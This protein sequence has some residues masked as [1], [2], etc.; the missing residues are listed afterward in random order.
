MPESTLQSGMGT[1]FIQL[2]PGSK[3]EFLGKHMV[4]EFSQGKGSKTLQW[5]KDP[6]GPDK[7]LV[8]GSYRDAPEPVKFSIE[9]LMALT[10]DYLE[11]IDGKFTLF[12]NYQTQ[13]RVDQFHVW[14]RCEILV[15]SDVANETR[16]GVAA[17]APDQRADVLYTVE[18]EAD[19]KIV[20][21]PIAIDRQ[22]TTEVQKAN[23]V[24]FLDKNRGYAVHNAVALGTANVQYTLDGGANWAAM[25]ADPFAADLHIMAVTAFY[26]GR[27]TIR[28]LVVRGTLAG[29]PLAV[30]YTDDN[31]ATWTVKTV[32]SVAAQAAQG[33][34]ALF[35]LDFRHI[36]LVASG[37]YIYFSSDGG[38]TWATQDAGISTT[39]ALNAVHFADSDHGIAVGQAGATLISHDGG[40]TWSVVT[41]PSV[42]N[43]Q[44]CAMIDRNTAW[45]GSNKAAGAQPLWVSRDGGT[46]WTGMSLNG[47]S[48]GKV[49][50]I[51]FVPDTNGLIGYAI[52]NT[53]APVGTLYL[54]RDGGVTWEAITTPLNAGLN[55]LHVV[56]ANLAY[57]VG[58]AQGGT[59]VMLKGNNGLM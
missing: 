41:S 59:A 9:A 40:A 22:N 50:G 3:P 1:L 24:F 46:T 44:S 57:A 29:Q 58:D 53:A 14:D 8:S 49:S 47:I 17:R 15:G 51:A 2:A 26:I 52:H 10:A 5:V 23:D 7:F 48:T 39:Q 33:G 4:E 25:A 38:D 37:G 45:V 11:K 56:S 6:S 35:A 12:V 55:A 34:G 54:S 18:C 43:H 13:G 30:A 16:S 31:G 20:M 19:R 42:D 28:V 21:Y 27:N 32:G 36:W